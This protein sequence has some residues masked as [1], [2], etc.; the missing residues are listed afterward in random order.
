M[1]QR[2]N[3]KRA[4]HMIAAA[5]LFAVVGGSGTAGANVVDFDSSRGGWAEALRE[6]ASGQGGGNARTAEDL[7]GLRRKL[8]K[9]DL[10]N[11]GAIN[12]L[13]RKTKPQ[14]APKRPIPKGGPAKM[15]GK[16]MR[17]HQKWMESFLKKEHKKAKRLSQRPLVV[18][19]VGAREAIDRINRI[20]EEFY[21]S[22][23]FLND[24]SLTDEMKR[25][26]PA[27]PLTFNLNA[28][29]ISGVFRPRR[30]HG[31]EVW[32]FSFWKTNH[33]GK[34][35]IV[36]VG[37]GKAALWVIWYNDKGIRIARLLITPW[38]FSR[39]LNAS[40]ASAG[41]HKSAKKP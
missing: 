5:A 32:K 37:Q 3:G 38:K 27:S 20:R 41:N 9:M 25:T 22:D 2:Q 11:K 12:T 6:A 39:Q 29:V 17:R 35:R 8:K 40:S 30:D 33:Q 18:F 16:Q 10:G 34:I 31:W 24:P 4:V 28:G 15:T 1:K 19:Q 36:P 21:S 26:Y 14:P 7:E 23:K 13:K